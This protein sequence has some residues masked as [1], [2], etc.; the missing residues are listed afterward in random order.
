M[1]EKILGMSKITINNKVTLVKEVVDKLNLEVGN[2]I[3]YI[4][5]NGKIFIRK[6]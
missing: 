4:S 6:A 2:K 5:Q 1:E 3:V